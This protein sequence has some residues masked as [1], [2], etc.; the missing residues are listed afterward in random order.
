M[1]PTSNQQSVYGSAPFK[2]VVDGNP[3]YIHA[4]L[5]SQHSYPLDR[6]INGQM[7]E[8]RKGFAVLE[9]VD[10]GTFKRFLEWAY[11]GYYKAAD[12]EDDRRKSPPPVPSNKEEAEMTEWPEHA[13]EPVPDDIPVAE[14]PAVEEPAVEEPT[15]EE[16]Y[17]EEPPAEEPPVE[18]PP[19]EECFEEP[20]WNWSK[21]TKTAK[22]SHELKLSFLRREYTVRREVISIPPAR[23][24]RVKFENYTEVFLS[25]ARLY[26]FAE[27]YDIQALKTLALEELHNT[28]KIYTLHRRRTGDIISLLRYSYANTG[29]PARGGEDL[30]ML[31]RDY[32][33]YEMKVLMMDEEFKDLM[34]EDGGALL[35]DFMQM[36]AKQITS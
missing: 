9:D 31:L 35:A 32:I 2:F 18:E 4:D 25:H 27:K 1:P 33:G 30:R 23:A 21:K 13:P 7:A 3:Y 34:V 12:F 8:A 20:A 29:M 26:V 14:E 6:M 5:V 36:V 22:T 16:M 10:E 28:L 17:A 11:K 15:L 19:A 24:N